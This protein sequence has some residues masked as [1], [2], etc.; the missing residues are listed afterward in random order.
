MNRY[1]WRFDRARRLASEAS[2]DGL[3]ITAGANFRW[4]TGEQAHP[5]GWPLWLSA[6]LVPVDGPAAMVFSK[7]HGEIFDV[8]QLPVREQ[9]TYLDG[10]SPLP[11]LR[12]AA[13]VSGLTDSRIG[14]DASLWLGDVELLA[15]ALPKL[16]R[17]YAADVFDHLR[18]VKDTSEIE[19]LRRAA[20]THDAGYEATREILRPGITVAEAGYEIVRA[21]VKAGSGELAIAGSFA[22]LTDRTFVDGDVVDVDLWPGSHN[23]YH[24]DSARNFFLGEPTPDARRL[25]EAT[26]RAYDAAV[27]AVRPGVTAESIHVACIEV[28]SEAGFDQVWKVGH[29]VGLAPIHE[30]PLLQMGNLEMIEPGM[31]FTIDPGAFL[32]RATPIHIEDTVVVTESGCESLNLF[33]REIQVL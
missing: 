2:L 33:T 7:M 24:A 18:A 29:G 10:E 11:A 21:M 9:F 19:S 4:L 23:S 1:E 27:A 5:G 14:S 31:V 6:I 17:V 25:H 32:A 26:S 30:P 22:E 13:A 16:T 20:H 28:M 12:S 3:Y 8:E 15:S